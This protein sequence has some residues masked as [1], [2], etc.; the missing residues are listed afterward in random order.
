MKRFVSLLILFVML[1][2]VFAF[3]GAFAK[4]TAGDANGDGA[5]DNKDVV[6]LFR[7]VSGNTS[8]AVS[9]NC[10]YNGDGNTDNKDVVALFRALSGLIPSDFEEFVITPDS[11][12]TLSIPRVFGDHM[13]IQ[14]GTAI[15][16]WGSSNK[17]GAKIRG[18]FMGE[19]ARGEVKNGNWEITF[20]SKK[21]TAEPQTL[22]VDDSCGNTLTFKN[23]LVGDVWVVGGQSNMEATV[24]DIPMSMEKLDP[25]ADRPLRVFHQ[26][27]RYVIDNSDKAAQP[28]EDIINPKWKWK[29]S[30]REGATTFS[31]LG[32]FIGSRLANESGVPIGVVSIAASGASLSEL[33][34]KELA[35]SLGYT[36]GSQLKPAYFYN[37][38]AHPF[39][40]MKFKGM[41]FC[42]GESESFYGANPPASNYDRDFEAL[43]TELRSRWGFDFP[44][45][46]IQLSDYTSK[47]VDQTSTGGYLPNTGVV[48]MNQYKAYKNMNGVRL[49]P[50]YD[51]GSDEGDANYLHS[52]YKKELANRVADLILADIY[53]VGQTEK[54]FAPEPLSITVTG[55][56][57]SQKTIEIKFKNT[58]NGLKTTDGSDTFSGF[59]S[60]RTS[61]P[62]YNTAD[63]TGKIISKDTVRITVASNMKYIGLACRAH[64]AKTDAKLVNSYGL[65]A[66][67]FYL[68]IQ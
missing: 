63:V 49:I 38:L 14:R 44:I 37:A 41:V 53:S 59:V 20:S 26:G 24:S 35:D 33:M 11:S 60:G 10:D 45:F 36:K 9:D 64:V 67:A 15:K 5:L 52:P 34:P 2:A 25:D 8:G 54:A 62:I 32:W 12:A 39:L 22:T 56:S 13:V 61:L 48:R 30:N 47:S 18:R 7:F 3:P 55:T 23:I 65:P 29:K 43:M 16:V 28:S 4:G 31:L 27:A 66:P 1:A 19:E 21:A 6:V 68:P 40:K 58:G 50:A 17:N 57:G 51:L 42:Q 46:N